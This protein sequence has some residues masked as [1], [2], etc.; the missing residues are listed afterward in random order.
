[1]SDDLGYHGLEHHACSLNG[2]KERDLIEDKNRKGWIANL[3]PHEYAHS[4]CGKFRRPAAMYT[5]DFHTPQRTKLLWVYE[6]LTM[7][8]GDALMIRSG[9]VS[10]KEYREMLAWTIGDQLQR[11]GRRWRSL[12]DT[13]VANYVL[14]APSLNWSDL[15]R[16]QD[17]YLEGLLLWL[18][19][20]VI[21]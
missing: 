10:A 6:G 1:C 16:G 20:D 14:R 7:Y 11:E 21:L 3:L 4:W 15:R 9:L 13:A 2:V 18:E 17:Y 12:E 8:L 5:T 19:A